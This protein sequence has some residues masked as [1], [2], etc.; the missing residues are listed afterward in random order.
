[1]LGKHKNFKQYY[2]RVNLVYFMILFG[3]ILS[4]SIFYFITQKTYFDFAQPDFL[5][6][7]GFM[8]VF[9]AYI[10]IYFA[11]EKILIHASMQGTAREKLQVYFQLLI[12]KWSLIEASGFYNVYL[13]ADTG[14]KVFL[15][16]AAAALLFLL[17][18]KPTTQKM[19]DDLLMTIHEMSFLKEPEKEFD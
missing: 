8:S 9:G 4:M 11:T 2:N 1:M 5:I 16:M 14:N 15:L 13:F 10:I 3:L 19:V 7:L 18:F 17:F 6:F 12:L